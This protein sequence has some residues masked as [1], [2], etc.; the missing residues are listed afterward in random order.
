MSAVRRAVQLGALLPY[1]ASA[2]V[3]ELTP[4]RALL[5]GWLAESAAP[6]TPAAEERAS[7]PLRHA[8]PWLLLHWLRPDAGWLAGAALLALMV[9]TRRWWSAGP[10]GRSA[11][12][13][14]LLVPPALDLALAV[15]GRAAPGA[16]AA[17]NAW[18]WSG[19]PPPRSSPPVELAEGVVRA[20]L[21]LELPQRLAPWPL[22][23]APQHERALLLLALLLGSLA[24]ATLLGGRRGAQLSLLGLPLAAGGFALAVQP[25]GLLVLYQRSAA[26]PASGGGQ[27][28]WLRLEVHRA[29]SDLYD[30]LRGPLLPPAS[31]FAL[32]LERELGLYRVVSPAP[33]AVVRAPAEP[34][35]GAEPLAWL[36]VHPLRAPALGGPG[37]EDWA[38]TL[39][40]WAAGE[41]DPAG[42]RWELLP[43][44]LHLIR[45][46][47][48]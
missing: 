40:L 9:L 42:A 45:R 2:L 36:E 43:G 23:D 16:L 13:L 48:P 10:G 34:P 1:A 24:A 27:G 28:G 31:S 35:E 26:D 5:L 47:L 25:E 37:A 18:D 33:W 8:C 38:G 6:G 41:R 12:V 17:A 7:F 14:L 15:S 44:G 30:P 29:G 3:P 39:R 46:R 19:V 22:E 32:R 11:V 4:A 21:A 20:D